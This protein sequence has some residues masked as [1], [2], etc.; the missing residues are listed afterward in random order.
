MEH[1]ITSKLKNKLIILDN[2]S[3]R[4]KERI[5]MFKPRLKKLEG[6]KYENLKKNINKVITEI[7]KKKYENIFKWAYNRDILCICKK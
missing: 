1:N 4:R 6:L 2:F 5:N 3:V 7:L